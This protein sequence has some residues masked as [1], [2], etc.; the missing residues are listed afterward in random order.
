[1]SHLIPYLVTAL[2]IGIVGFVVRSARRSPY[3]VDPE[4]YELAYSQVAD[5]QVSRIMLSASRR[6][7]S[8]PSIHASQS[9]A[10]YR[11]LERKLVA[12]GGAFGDSVEI[13]LGVQIAAAMTSAA[14]LVILLLT[15]PGALWFIVGLLFAFGLLGYP[16][17]QVRRRVMERADAVSD[18]LPDFAELLLMPISQGMGIVPALRFTT[19]RSEGH[20]ADE[21]NSMLLMLE[22]QTLEDDRL[23]F[24]LA[25][26]RLGTSEA[27][28]FCNALMM[29]HVESTGVAKNIAAQAKSLR[30][31]Q[32]QK[33]RATAKKLPV[34]L[35]ILFTGNLL[36]LLFTVILIPVAVGF[37][38][39]F[40]G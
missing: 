7:S 34:K 12:S 31:S 17:D 26:N 24:T 3:Q 37:T 19:D 1:M 9:S 38:K 11:S 35:V 10:L 2:F 27:I 20:V 22:S 15:M 8:L 6:F 29:A 4:R 14:I 23:P 21:I 16:Y 25:G 28:S 13:F 40:G 36:P 18:Q 32:F 5:S 30:L 39:S 33:S